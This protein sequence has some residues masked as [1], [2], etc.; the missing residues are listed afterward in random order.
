MASKFHGGI[1]F[2]LPTCDREVRTVESDQ[3]ERL[4]EAVSFGKKT[5]KT[6]A[7][8]AHDE[9]LAEVEGS[10]IIEQ[11]GEK[12]ID[13]L[14]RVLSASPYK[15]RLAA[16]VCFDLDPLSQTNSSI[17]ETDADAVAGGLTIL[18]KLL[19][20][21]EGILLCDSRCK[22]SVR[23][24]EQ[25]AAHSKLIAI[26]RTVNRY[27]QANARLVTRWLVDKELSASKAPEDAGLFLTDAETCASLY[28]LF[29]DGMPALSKRVSVF[30]GG[31]LKIYDLPYGL[32]LSALPKLGVL[33]APDEKTILCRGGMDGRPLPETVDATLNSIALL[34]KNG[35]HASQIL[36]TDE[37]DASD[38]KNVRTDTLSARSTPS[39]CIS[40]GRCAAVCPMF[41]LPYDYLPKNRLQRWLSGSPRDGHACI[42]CG[43]CSY[44]C[45][46][47]LP[48]RSAV[49]SA[50][51][52]EDQD[53]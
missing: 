50:S 19:R 40:C 37:T 43:C 22:E 9:L 15:L 4:A 8:A 53:G 14:K 17:T 6:L 32:D 42:G 47:G 33:P 1:A 5:G 10:G 31:M 18:L 24:A 28:C 25:A 2:G 26:E 45:P 38:A 36:P 11:S 35:S 52:K 34:P 39:E 16:V 23:A 41:L 20:L 46:S 13:H 12:L 7:D 44:I 30:A 27:P 21:R 48:L 51:R 29:A 3:T 49:L